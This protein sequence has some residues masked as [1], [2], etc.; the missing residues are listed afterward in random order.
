MDAAISHLVGVFGRA[1]DILVNNL[2]LADPIPFESYSDVPAYAA[3]WA[4]DH[5]DTPMIAP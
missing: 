5:P 2:G 3:K 4:V 1:P